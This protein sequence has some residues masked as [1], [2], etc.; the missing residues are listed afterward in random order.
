MPSLT[1]VDH[2]ALVNVSTN[3]IGVLFV[4][5]L[6]FEDNCKGTVVVLLVGSKSDKESVLLFDMSSRY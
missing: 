3:G 5:L 4:G 1:D 2:W 6:G